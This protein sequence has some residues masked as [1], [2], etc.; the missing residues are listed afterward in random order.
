LVA[1]DGG[2]PAVP[3]KLQVRLVDVDP[4]FARL[5]PVEEREQARAVKLPA[6]DLPQGNFT[7]QTFL[8]RPGGGT[9]S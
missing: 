8:S 5:L 6:I 3:A 9:A 2:D 4:D 7:L 1:T